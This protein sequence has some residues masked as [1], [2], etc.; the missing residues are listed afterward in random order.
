MKSS[1]LSIRLKNQYGYSP[2]SEPFELIIVN[3]DQLDD[4]TTV[5]PI[6][7]PSLLPSKPVIEQAV[8]AFKSLFIKWSLDNNGGSDINQIAIFVLRYGLN[9]VVSTYTQGNFFK[10]IYLSCSQKQKC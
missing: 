5:Q 4:S 8:Y 9:G 10:S 7:D 2:S 1:F 3:K 6:V